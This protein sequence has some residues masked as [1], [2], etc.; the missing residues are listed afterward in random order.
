MNIRFH[1]KRNNFTPFCSRSISDYISRIAH[2]FGV[3]MAK[4]KNIPKQIKLTVAVASEH[5]VNV[6]L[7]TPTV[8]FSFLVF[9]HHCITV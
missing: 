2:E 6:V 8:C 7:K 9:Y 5:S 4:N 1:R 3:K